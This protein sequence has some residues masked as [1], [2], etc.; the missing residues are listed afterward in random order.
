[1]INHYIIVL[2]RID[3]EHCIKHQVFGKNSSQII[4]KIKKGDKIACYITGE[5]KF[6]ALGEAT[7]DYYLD[8]KKIFKAE[9]LFPD[10]FNF[11][12]KLLED[13]ELEVKKIVNDLDFVTRKEYWS[14]YFRTGPKKISQ[15]DWDTIKKKS[16]I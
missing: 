15:K 5:C 10:R 9:G 1:M 12:A 11:K 2:P 14:V 13:N 4:S 16:G 7:S 6:I 3:M 8:D